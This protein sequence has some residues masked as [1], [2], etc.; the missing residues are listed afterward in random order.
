MRLV[1]TLKFL[2]QLLLKQIPEDFS[3]L[4]TQDTEALVFLVENLLPILDE[5]VKI[6]IECC[7]AVIPLNKNLKEYVSR[8][9]QKDLKSD[10][11]KFQVQLIYKSEQDS[12]IIIA[13]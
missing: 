10:C 9:F 7:R 1:G 2:L 11:T 12:D 3:K 13:C 4:G 5:F 8:Y 6:S